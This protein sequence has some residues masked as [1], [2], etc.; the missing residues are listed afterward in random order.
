MLAIAFVAGAGS[1]APA[2]AQDAGERPTRAQDAAEAWD[3]FRSAW[4]PADD[5][6]TVLSGLAGAAAEL[7]DLPRFHAFLDSVIGGE[8][9]GPNALRYWGAVGLQLGVPP[10]SV[11]RAFAASLDTEANVVELAALVGVLE[12]HEAVEAAL[13][14][15]DDAAAVGVPPGRV[16]LVRGQLLA[17]SGDPE[18]AVDAW[19]LALGAGGEEAVAAA[20]RI[21]DMAVGGHGVPAGTV[22][23]LAG[24]R[25]VAAGE[26]ASAIAILQARVHAS[27]GSWTE[28]LEAA[29]DPALG[30]MARGEALRGI[31]STAREAGQPEAARDALQTLVALGT[32]AARAE[33]RLA[34][35]EL[36]DRLGSPAA[37][38]ASFEAARLEGA[39]GARAME[40]AAQVDAARASGD[41]D[42]LSR[43]LEEVLAAGADP[44]ILAV[45]RGDLF[46]SRARPDSAL[47]AYAAGVGDGPVGPPGLEALSRLRLA[48]ALARSGTGGDVVEQIGDA[49]VRAPADPAAASA[50]LAALA[51]RLGD[52]D[53]L[54][55]ARSLVLGLAAE[56][57]GRAGDPAG[58]SE[59]L[60]RAALAAVSRGEAPALL[61]DAGRW[62]EE[63]GDHERA[64][65]LWRSVV[66]EHGSTPYALDARRRLADEGR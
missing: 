55:V 63:A 33:D 27:T 42:A 16:A 56:W 61:L 64:R 57:K 38:A 20:A 5:R 26:V 35:G 54:A 49:L 31:A 52:A 58:A 8:G 1:V 4:D 10:D 6:M 21:G 25:A 43:T 46:L 12:A 15:L 32:P 39:S 9:G 30:P 14:V 17:R 18:L 45:P 3:R 50:R 7:G 19:L 34:L 36:E 62:A 41:P 37:A 40:L 59:A 47:S 65:R 24:L 44:A 2:R 22:E 28:A 23:R 51:G 53:S 11:A 60:E 13:G 66:D 29:A 48:Q